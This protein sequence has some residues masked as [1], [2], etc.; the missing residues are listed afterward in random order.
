MRRRHHRPAKR[1]L[2]LPALLLVALLAGLHVVDQLHPRPVDTRLAVDA[3]EVGAASADAVP[4]DRTDP[5]TVDRVR[6][7]DGSA[8]VTSTQVHACPEAYDGRRIRYVGELVGD[9]LPRRDGSWVQVNDDAY[10]LEVGPLPGHRDLRGS[11]TGLAVW[12]PDAL[13]H[14]PTG[15]G[16]PDQRGEV[17]ALEGT[18][19]RTDPEDGDGLTL[20][21]DR[22]EVLAPAVTVEEPLDR[23]QLWFAVGASLAAAGAWVVRRRAAGP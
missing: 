2:V 13:G 3:D 10:A 1:L 8:R 4:C 21:A 12:L 20:R 6:P 11:N 18:L 14:V 16:R 15:L 22:I 19:L 17:V 7:S 5:F 23:P 9:L